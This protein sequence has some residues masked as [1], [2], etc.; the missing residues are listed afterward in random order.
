MKIKFLFIVFAIVS[1][2]VFSACEKEKFIDEAGNLVPETVDQ[3][4]T[5]PSITANGALLHSEAF[6]D[7]NNTMV[8]CVHG[9]PGSDHRYM[10][11][12]MG[13]ADHGYYVVFYSQLGS[14][15]SQR[16]PESYYTDLEKEGIN[17]VYDEL[18]DVIAHYR[19][20]L[21][22][23]IFLL[24][25]SWG[26]MLVTGYTGKNPDAIDGLVVCEPGGLKWD[27]VVSYISDSRSFGLFGE[28]L[29]DVTYLDQFISGKEDQHEVLDYKMAMMTAE[30]DI[31]GD[32]D[33]QPGS[34]WRPGAAIS[35]AYFK[36]GTEYEP[37]F[38]EGIS[39]FDIP[40]LFFY[41]EKNKVYTDSWAQ[42]ISGAYNSVELFKVSGTGHSGIV[43]DDIAWENQTMPEILNYFNS[44]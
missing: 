28:L 32:D 26:G 2:A 43:S 4:P 38:S 5:L 20:S 23:K 27:D 17:L 21:E 13:L 11:N 6:G 29:N 34:I 1:T 18:S 22:Q 40:V 42:N 9:G 36:L 30:N 25:H 10:L 15:L 35:T 37:D 19:T 8:V 39:K 12:C 24:G 44:L 14:G 3:D 16:F 33:T 41:S 31:T 7:P